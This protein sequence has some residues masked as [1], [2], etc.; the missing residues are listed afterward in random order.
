M[1]GIRLYVYV[2]SILKHREVIK[3][4]IED[5]NRENEGKNDAVKDEY[6]LVPYEGRPEFEKGTWGLLISDDTFLLTEFSSYEGFNT[7]YIGNCKDLDE[8][9][10]KRIDNILS[11]DM[12]K[13]VLYKGITH[14]VEGV[15][16]RYRAWLY[17]YLMQSII[18][19]SPDM[20]WVKDEMGRHVVLNEMFG[21]IVNKD[22]R[23]CLYKEHPEIWN[24]SREEYESSDF[25]CR[26]SEEAIIS[27]GKKGTFEELVQTGG[28]MKQFTTYKAPLYDSLGNVLGTCGIGHDVTGLN[29]MGIEM[30]MLIENIPFPMVVLSKDWKTVRMNT[31]LKELTG[32]HQSE[33][34]DYR[35]W[36][37]A[38]LNPVGEQTESEDK[39]SYRQEFTYANEDKNWSF[40]IYE[41][42]ITDFMGNVSGYF[43]MMQDVTYQRMYEESILT[44]ANTDV[45][46]GLYNRRYFYRYLEKNINSPM[47]LLYMDLDNFKRINDTYSHAR[48]DDILKRTADLIREIYPE[49][50]AAR[51][52]GDEYAALLEGTV[53][54]TEIDVKNHRLEQAVRNLCRPGGPYVTI[55]IGK[56]YT[57]GTKSAD[58]LINDGDS[59]MYEIKKKHHDIMDNDPATYETGKR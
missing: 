33:Q 36:I 57:D 49:A 26:R 54:S 16:T 50:V 48:G 25:A 8:N 30:S 6:I 51:L 56:A 11:V 24:I 59:I 14:I 42:A 2:D 41:Q 17:Q 9:E 35:D 31:S 38:N 46:T 13:L 3:A 37:S 4:V 43:C 34:F 47:T 12:P 20:V 23:D 15:I 52:G 19:S 1:I 58:E 21:K 10:Q 5:K 7:L 40:C 22:V 29:N 18:D 28:D 32:I 39:R 55:S 44:A 53:N 27:T 45:L